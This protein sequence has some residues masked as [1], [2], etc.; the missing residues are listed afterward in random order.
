MPEGLIENVTFFTGN[1]DPQKIIYTNVIEEE[2]EGEFNMYEIQEN[3]T[4]YGTSSEVNTSEVNVSEEIAQENNQ[5]S[6]FNLGAYGD[7]QPPISI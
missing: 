2:S 5:I 6:S 4:S 3:A 7:E 1:Y